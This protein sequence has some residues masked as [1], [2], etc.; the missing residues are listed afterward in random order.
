MECEV[1]DVSRI[2]S[3]SNQAPGSA[4]S[5]PKGASQLP[6]VLPNT[7]SALSHILSSSS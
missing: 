2:D 1:V 4:S 5:N 6:E 3:P 7:A